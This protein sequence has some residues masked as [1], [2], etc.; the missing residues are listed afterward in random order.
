MCRLLGSLDQN[1]VCLWVGV[2]V[3]VFN[4]TIDLLAAK[5]LASFD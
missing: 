4:S 5:I 2:G 3:C 1:N